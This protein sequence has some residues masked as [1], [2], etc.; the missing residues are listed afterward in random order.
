VLVGVRY[1]A[2]QRGI[3]MRVRGAQ[4]SVWRVFEATGQDQVFT[5]AE[6]SPAAPMQEL[7]LF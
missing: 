5:G 3:A 1:W 6:E 7:A 4:P 2:L